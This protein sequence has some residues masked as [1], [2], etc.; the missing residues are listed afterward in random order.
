[1]ETEI[2]VKEAMVNTVVTIKT[3]STISEAAKKMIAH[4]IGC[5][6]VM[7]KNEPVGIITERDVVRVVAEK[8]NPESTKVKSIMSSPIISAA[9]G[10]KLFEAARMMSKFN[11]RRLPVMEN[12]KLQGIITSLDILRFAPEEAD[13]LSELAKINTSMPSTDGVAGECERCGKYSEYLKDA[14][15]TI[16]CEKCRE[17]SEEE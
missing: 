7:D 12:K 2:T 17:E 9:P 14:E 10:T 13:I 4:Q 6:V 8:K 5:L 11:I 3:T 1:M 16:L 15:G